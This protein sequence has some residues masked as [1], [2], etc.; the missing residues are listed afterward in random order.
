MFGSVWSLILK[1][2]SAG[3]LAAL[4]INYGG[5]LLGLACSEQRLALSSLHRD[6]KDLQGT[7][8]SLEWEGSDV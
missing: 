8:R 3:E 2:S 5:L 4:P 1:D 6:S 7:V